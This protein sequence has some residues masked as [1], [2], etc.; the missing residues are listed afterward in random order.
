MRSHFISSI[1]IG[2]ALTK[3]PYI[4]YTRSL[5]N[6]LFGIVDFGGDYRLLCLPGE[7]IDA[8]KEHFN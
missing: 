5:Q 2:N 4:S 1:G 8:H 7:M 3:Y 6:R